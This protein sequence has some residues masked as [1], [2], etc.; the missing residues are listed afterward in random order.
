[1]KGL[2]KVD[3]IKLTE[4]TPP[5]GIP[6]F[7]ALLKSVGCC[8]IFGKFI[9]LTTKIQQRSIRNKCDDKLFY[10]ISYESKVQ[11]Y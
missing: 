6:Y 11:T 3:S 8:S 1:M 7:M 10:L 5:I 4:K 9:S 2:L